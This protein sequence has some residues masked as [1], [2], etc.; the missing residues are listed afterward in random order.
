[1][2][3][4][5]KIIEEDPMS[6]SYENNK[7]VVVAGYA[8]IARSLIADGVETPKDAVNSIKERFAGDKIF[9]DIFPTIFN[10]EFC[11]HKMKR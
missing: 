9:F 10:I 4:L 8:E 11:K 6:N 3:Q 2:S 5:N 7:M 1:M